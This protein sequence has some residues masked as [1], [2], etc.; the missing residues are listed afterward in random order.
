MC[1]RTNQH[2]RH[3]LQ[4]GGDVHGSIRWG[5]HLHSARHG[6]NHDRDHYLSFVYSGDAGSN[7][8]GKATSLL[9]GW[10]TGNHIPILPDDESDSFALIVDNPDFTLTSTTGP[11]SVV[12]APSER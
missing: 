6:G 8:D 1:D 5:R 2:C 3:S 11:I 10:A 9:G 4:H 12:P 7:G